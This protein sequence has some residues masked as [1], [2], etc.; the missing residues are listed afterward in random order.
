[1]KFQGRGVLTAAVRNAAGAYGVEFDFGCLD[2]LKLGLKAD[3]FTHIE[4]C[5][6]ADGI[7]YRGTKS[8]DGTI[9]LSFTEF[10]RKA[11][12]LALQAAFHS[13]SGDKTGSITAEIINADKIAPGD[14][15]RPKRGGA[16]TVVITDSTPVTPA[17]I[18]SGQYNLVAGKIV[19]DTDFDDAALVY[20]LKVAYA[21]TEA[22]YLSFF[23]TGQVELFLRFEGLNKANSNAPVT[24]EFYRVLFD[25][26]SDVDFLSNEIGQ[27]NLSGSLLIDDSKAASGELGQYG[28]LM[29]ATFV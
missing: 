25:P 26:A 21:Y 8:L 14:K 10:K 29:D 2:E 27:F 9:T 3:T 18:P 20:P 5:S 15:Y 4:K 6:G 17:T 7:D 13:V 11:L 12:A 23:Q 22:N 24:G 19:F 28:R 16:T 1:M